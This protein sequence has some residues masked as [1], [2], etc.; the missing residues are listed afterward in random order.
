VLPGYTVFSSRDADLAAKYLLRRG[1]VR[2]KPP[3]SCGGGGQTVVTLAHQVKAFLEQYSREELALYGLVLEMDLSRVTTL[4]VGQITIDNTVVTYHG[5][6]RTAHNN[7]RESVYGGSDLICVRGNWDALKDMPMNSYRRKAVAQAMCYDAASEEYP[8]FLASRRNYD[9]CQG[10]DSEGRRRSGVL[11]ASWRSGGATTAELGALS[12]FLREPALRI[13]EVS[14]MKMFGDRVEP[15]RSA[16]VH[17]C[18]NDPRD[19]PIL[20]YTVVTRELR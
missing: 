18:G 15:P 7:K 9:V 2:L 1:P 8:G 16:V 19:G 10:I 17:F 5:T 6:Q 13:V 12:A 14:T 20:R 3:L 11:E 4:S